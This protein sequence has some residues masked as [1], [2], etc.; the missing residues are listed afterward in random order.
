MSKHP[1]S[2][3]SALVIH[4]ILIESTYLA[5]RFLDQ[6]AEALA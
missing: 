2:A 1:P 3:V 4:L 6:L 5:H